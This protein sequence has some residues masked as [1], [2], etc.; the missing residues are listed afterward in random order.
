[1]LKSLML[2]SYP[3]LEQFFLPKLPKSD[4]ELYF[5]ATCLINDYEICHKEEQ[6]HKSI[7]CNFL[8]GIAN[9]LFPFT[10]NNAPFLMKILSA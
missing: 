1:M 7:G 10:L 9:G 3:I 2:L 4:S 6:S 8:R 5:T